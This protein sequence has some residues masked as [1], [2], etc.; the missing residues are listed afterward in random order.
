MERGLRQRPV[1]GGASLAPDGSQSLQHVRRRAEKI[2][3]QGASMAVLKSIVLGRLLP[4][5]RDALQNIEIAFEAVRAVWSGVEVRA[6]GAAERWEGLARRPTS[7]EGNGGWLDAIQANWTGSSLMMRHALR[8]AVVGG[9]DVLLMRTVHL[10]HGTW[11]AMT[12]IIVLQPYGSGTLRKTLQRVVGT[13]AG[14]VVAAVLVATIPNQTGIIVVITVTSVLTLAT[15]AVDYGWYTFF[16]TPTFV[17]MSLPQ[18][19][20]WRYAEVRIGTTM[21]GALVAMAAMWLLWPE[22]EGLELGRLLGQGAAADAAYA[23]AMLQYWLLPAEQ[24]AAA[25][26]ELMAPARRRCGLAINDA[27]ETL[28]R[29]LLEPTL[30]RRSSSGKDMKSTSLT[31]VTYL[32]RL[33]RS[34]TTLE[35]IGL[36]DASAVKRVEAVAVRLEKVSAVLLSEQRVGTAIA[37]ELPKATE[38]PAGIAE[39][40]IRRMERQT[41][42][43]ERAAVEILQETA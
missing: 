37:I 14:A 18:L 9:V 30:A 40:Q 5:Q 10:S 11:L 38:T 3:Q 21:I 27:E 42:V 41:A 31:F 23:R 13:V 29:M 28:D 2:Q 4:D 32:R 26:R 19:R 43:M 33:T 8:M 34:V 24:R 1:D 25:D 36:G 12:S 20:D 17:L 15:F 7:S 22:R 6:G 16:L 39:Q 35:G